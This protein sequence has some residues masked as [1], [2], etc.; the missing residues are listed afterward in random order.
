MRTHGGGGGGGAFACGFCEVGNLF[1]VNPTVASFCVSVSLKERKRR[2]K[3][4][5]RR[6]RKKKKKGEQTNEKTKQKKKEEANSE[7]A[8]PDLLTLDAQIYIEGLKRA[9]RSI[10][11]MCVPTMALPCHL[12]ALLDQSL[13]QLSCRH[14]CPT[15]PCHRGAVSPPRPELPASS[16][17]PPPPPPPTTPISI[18]VAAPNYCCIV[19]SL[20][21]DWTCVEI[22]VIASSV[23]FCGVVFHRLLGTGR[24][25]G[26]FYL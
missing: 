5:R 16:S 3:K 13:A 22:A 9:G 12:T 19:A 14:H 1:F 8:D 10:R 25:N 24:G 26:L 18:S 23:V 4:N 2:R 7:P 21:I 6:R 17:S 15:P 20:G 11:P